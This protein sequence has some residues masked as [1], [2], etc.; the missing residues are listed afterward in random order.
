MGQQL[1]IIVDHAIVVVIAVFFVV[2]VVVVS[3]SMLCGTTVTL[4][5]EEHVANVNCRIEEW[6]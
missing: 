5:G 1:L 2:L 3:F 4:R 6:V